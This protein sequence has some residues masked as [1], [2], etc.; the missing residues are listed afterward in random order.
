MDAVRICQEE[1]RNRPSLYF[2][3]AV[4]GKSAQNPSNLLAFATPFQIPGGAALKVACYYR[5]NTMKVVYARAW[6]LTD[7]GIMVD[8]DPQA[9]QVL[10]SGHPSGPPL[11]SRSLSFLKTHGYCLGP[12]L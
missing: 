12:Q 5:P 8:L 4:K 6:A 1:S 3:D 11:D 10:N 7:E 9:G 2:P